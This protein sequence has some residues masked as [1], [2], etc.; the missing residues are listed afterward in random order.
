MHGAAGVGD[1]EKQGQ[2]LSVGRGLRSRSSRAEQMPVWLFWLLADRG[3][4]PLAGVRALWRFIDG[5]GRFCFALLELGFISRGVPLIH[6]LHSNQ[7]RLTV[8]Q[9]MASVPC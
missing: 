6:L 7:Q 2:G 4:T 1:D 8:F 5:A 3:V 9:A